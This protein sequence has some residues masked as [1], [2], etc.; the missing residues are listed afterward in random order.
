MITLDDLHVICPSVNQARIEPFV[1]P[2]NDAMHEFDIDANTERETAFLAQICHESG[3]FYYVRELA[4]GDAYEGRSDLGNTEPGDGRKFK[5]RGLIQ[6]TGR[7]NYAACGDALGLDLCDKPELLEQPI[8]A[9]RSAGWFWHKRGLNELADA[10]DFLHITKRI[11]GGT[12]GWEDR[13]AY[14]KRAQK[15]LA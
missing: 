12:N 4:S 8:A 1:D 11:N 15:A 14:L 2:L 9:C 5:G 6:I 10:G 3:G 13:L 7:S